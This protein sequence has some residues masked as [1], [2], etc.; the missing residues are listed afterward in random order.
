M[1]WPWL[2]LF[3][4]S[5]L[6]VAFNSFGS[7]CHNTSKQRSVSIVDLQTL[8]VSIIKYVSVSVG[9]C[10][11]WMR[12]FLAPSLRFLHRLCVIHLTRSPTVLS[13][14]QRFLPER[15]SIKISPPTF[16][17]WNK[18]R[19]AGPLPNAKPS[20]L[21]P[22]SL[23]LSLD[24][25]RLAT[26]LLET[27]PLSFAGFTCICRAWMLFR[28]FSGFAWMPPASLIACKAV[29]TRP[30]FLLVGIRGQSRDMQSVSALSYSPL[31]KRR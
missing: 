29:S 8:F 5:W 16:Y 26:S 13:E 10:C 6:W 4:F 11:S 3:Y 12:S 24:R 25:L 31:P 1:H 23:S 17:Y 20:S 2:K 19:A 21:M 18:F 27:A 14:T 15:A 7:S 30:F 28:L 22:L 9:L